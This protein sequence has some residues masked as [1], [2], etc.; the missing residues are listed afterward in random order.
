MGSD[1]IGF[2]F[3]KLCLWCRQWM[4]QALG[5]EV[6]LEACGLGCT[7]AYCLLRAVFRDLTFLPHRTRR[8]RDRW[9]DDIMLPPPS[10]IVTE[11]GYQGGQNSRVRSL[12]FSPA[13]G[14]SLC[15]PAMNGDS[16][17]RPYVLG[18]SGKAL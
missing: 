8:R 9:A 7:T 17:T 12:G 15:L 16:S 2:S 1:M 11:M 13:S 10:P 18:R 5:V 14:L 6:A 3:Q 4:A